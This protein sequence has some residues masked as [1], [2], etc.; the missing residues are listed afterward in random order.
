MSTLTLS[1][2]D[3][4]RLDVQ[5]EQAL[6][7]LAATVKGT[8]TTSIFNE[9]TAE[10]VKNL[11]RDF[12][13]QLSD[14][15]E[16]TS[17]RFGLRDAVK[18]ANREEVDALTNS[19]ARLEAT[20]KFKQE[21]LTPAVEDPYSHRRRSTQTTKLAA[22][23]LVNVVELN[24][25]VGAWRESVKNGGQQGTSFELPFVTTAM[26]SKLSA[27]VAKLK[28]EINKAKDALASA[29]IKGVVKLST[30][31]EQDSLLRKYNLWVE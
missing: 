20:L 30:T 31:T 2:R 1:L 15:A 7:A 22:T 8:K 29:N 13:T 11:Q 4:R 17:F 3:A 9:V 25:Q 21:V 18:R 19:L 23:D 28:R 16:L 24:A 12:E 14:A 6:V 26:A 10:M 27:D 5:V